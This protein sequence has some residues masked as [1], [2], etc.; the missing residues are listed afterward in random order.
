[1]SRI[2]HLVRTTLSDARNSSADEKAR[3]PNPNSLIK[4]GRDSR[5]D[6]SSSTTDTSEISAVPFFCVNFMTQECARPGAV[7]IVLW[8]RLK[9]HQ[10]QFSTFMQLRPRRASE[11]RYGRPPK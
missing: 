2:K 8:Y 4:S 10:N 11:Y 3:A 5:T 9:R 1:M 7:S 6:S